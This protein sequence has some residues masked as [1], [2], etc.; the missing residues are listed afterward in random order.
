MRNPKFWWC[1]NLAG[2]VSGWIM[3]L[4][5]FTMFLSTAGCELQ[6]VD[7]PLPADPVSR[8]DDTDQA[9][10]VTLGEDY[11]LPAWAEPDDYSGY[12]ASRDLPRPE[13]SLKVE[14]CWLSWAD[15]EPEQGVYNW[16]MVENRLAAA[17]AG[18]YQLNLHLQSITLGGGDPDLGIVV[19]PK[20]PGWVVDEFA[21]AEDE[22]I[23][24]GWEFDLLIIPGWRQDIREAFQNLIL[25]FG[26]RGYPQSPQIASAYI[27]GLSPSRGEEFWMT[28]PALTI[29]EH[30][31]GFSPQILEEWITSRLDAYAQAFAGQTHKLVWVGKQG[32]WRYLNSGEYAETALNLVQHAW[33][34][35]AGNRSSAIEYYNEWL[36]EPALGQE[37]DSDGYLLV[38][39]SIAPLNSVRYFG[40][41]NEEYGPN[42]VW[43]F[44]SQE[45][46][47]LRYRFSLLRALQMRMRFLWTSEAAEAINPGLSTYTA[48]SLG[49]TP[50][51]S[52][53]A[54]AYLRESPINSADT[55]S[56]VVRNLERWLMQRDL[57]G[58][59]TVPAQR[60]Y[61]EFN[62][63]SNYQG[64]ADSWYDDIARRTDLASGNT[65]IFFA[66]DDRF[67]VDGTVQ[68]KV[69]ILD[70]SPA[71][72]HLE[73]LDSHRALAAT[74]SFTNSD[75]GQVKTVTFTVDDA[76]FTNGLANGMDFKIVCEG[77]GDVTVRW[78]RL[79]RMDEP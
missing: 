71:E 47:P 53:D 12:V 17:E 20:V 19:G 79:I 75:D 29:L 39:E 50:E 28:Q 63:G 1:R 69:E 32:S 23:N 14:N 31:H 21:L 41:E 56:H 61:R 25:A 11:Q 59:M 27:H 64:N 70:D 57:P 44:G 55:P 72:W 78:V 13:G 54:W 6:P 60:T 62:A 42:W 26:E 74:P 45:G 43:R 36:E 58:G 5:L 68:I 40:D 67:H 4:F 51:D 34:L 3:I 30:E 35:G 49:K 16:Q 73:Y 10:T 33:D 7:D 76:S 18:G 22:I 24:L 77:P 66:L 2:G 8:N 9:P 38:D 52:P 48:M 46:E 37:I 65:D 15:L